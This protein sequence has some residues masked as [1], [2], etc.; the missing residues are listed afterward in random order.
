[1]IAVNKNLISNPK[2]EFN[3]GESVWVEVKVNDKK[4]LFI[5]CV[6]LPPPVNATKL[7]EFD[8]SLALVR[9]AMRE[10]DEMLI[11]GDFNLPDI[12]WSATDTPHKVTPTLSQYS[13]LSCDFLQTINTHDL[14][15]HVSF[16]TRGKNTL[17]LCLSANSDNYDIMVRPTDNAVY[18][19]HTHL[20]CNI[21]MRSPIYRQKPAKQKF[22]KWW[23]ADIT[24]LKHLLN[25]FC[26]WNLLE[27]M[28]VNDACTVFYDLLE[29]AIKDCVPIV[30]SK[31]KKF[32]N[33]YDNELIK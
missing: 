19:D 3:H 5:G 23:K 29:A 6:Y 14:A 17:D 2:F 28:P 33:W 31:C 27:N 8:T 32:P 4:K 7:E 16:E 21:N 15:Q 26:P 24:A 20:E 1:M 11:C 30:E 25:N 9:A 18:S 22:Y 10:E 12:T 13:D